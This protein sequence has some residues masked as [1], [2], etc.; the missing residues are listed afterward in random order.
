MRP[1]IWTLG[2]LLALSSTPAAATG[3]VPSIIYS[4]GTIITMDG[5]R[6]Q[7]VEAV[8][9][10][11]GK[12]IFTG[13][14]A[15]AKNR[16]GPDAQLHS[17]RGATMLPGF[18]DA[19]SHF[20]LAM[21]AA[22][23]LDL[24]DPALPPVTD[25]ASLTKALRTY[26][27]V[28]AVREGQWVIG[29]QYDQDKLAEHRHI[30]RDEI[31]AVL[32]NHKVLLLHVSL[33]GLVANSAALKAAGIEDSSPVPPGGIMPHDCQGRLT[34]LLF[35]KASYL[36][37]PHLPQPTEEQRLAALEI[38]QNHY[39]REGFTHAQEGA[40]QLA[41]MTFL[42]SNSAR[43][44]LKIDLAILPFHTGLDALLAN[45]TIKFGEY[46]GHVKLQGIKFVIDGSP[47]ARTAFSTRAYAL[48]SPEGVH[49]WFAQP[50]MDESEFQAKA[51]QVYDRGW[52]IFVHANGDAAIDMAIRAFDTLGIKA[53]DDRRPVVIHSQFMRPE[54]IPAYVR[55]GV[56]PAF[57]T[58]H[59]YYWADTH[60]TNFNKKVVDFISPMRAAKDAGLVISN[61]S[62]HPVTPLDTR[63]QLWTSMARI[64]KAGAVIG[65]AQRLDAYSAVQALTTGPAWQ[66]FEEGRKGRIKAGLLADFVILDKNPL[67]TPVDDIRGINVLET[68]KEGESVWKRGR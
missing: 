6:P 4:G 34:G 38:A 49:P 68:I 60:L 22:S 58:N 23:G 51:K 30:T 32:P 52:Q 43:S 8:V 18:I 27:A 24:T 46:H 21:Q 35:E 37:L 67:T 39:F 10:H 64:S 42:T 16:A 9:V 29:W 59:T 53:A 63:F 17:L 26:V 33:H 19:H 47:Q 45:R 40:T 13:S 56:G 57:F 61:H 28:H 54:Q 55:I 44:K 7:T 12:I 31:D 3:D 5:N 2:L 65:P 25:I 1:W 20:A 62:D 50:T 48:G 41:D 66:I 15:E 36:M 11:D 14:A